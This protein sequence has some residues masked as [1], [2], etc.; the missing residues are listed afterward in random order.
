MLVER[1]RRQIIRPQRLKANSE[2]ESSFIGSS[3]VPADTST[4]RETGTS[5]RGE[6][7]RRT[8][9]V[10]LRT[11]GTAGALTGDLLPPSS[12]DRSNDVPP[13]TAAAG[14]AEPSEQTLLRVTH[15]MPRGEMPETAY[16]TP[17]EL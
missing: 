6:R 11:G 8:R 9:L 16:L 17:E 15:T 4:S 13:R 12:Y 1:P 7:Q 14:G 2:T 3:A 5:P 10:V